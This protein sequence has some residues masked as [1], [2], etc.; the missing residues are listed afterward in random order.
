[1]T[2]SEEA[3]VATSITESA[4]EAVGG[5]GE[6]KAP[7]DGQ[8]EPAEPILD[9]DELFHL[10]QSE[11]RRLA[12][13]Y[14]LAADAEPIVMRDVAEAVAADEYDTTVALLG[15]E[16][17]QRV[18]ITMYQSHLPQL[19]EA[20]VI[21]YD[22]DRGEITTT[23]LIEEFEEY[24]GEKPPDDGDS[25]KRVWGATGF[26]LGTLLT[27]VLLSVLGAVVTLGVT[28]LALAAVIAVGVREG[29]R[30]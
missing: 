15:S 18:Y 7:S 24:L 11:R 23:P 10:L 12:I 21:T 19:A 2:G 30:I 27:F 28:L 20:G 17:R 4:S 3:S 26:G 25:T 9:N 8:D 13:R 29:E 22:Q 16:K 1:M 14:L 6:R 5:D